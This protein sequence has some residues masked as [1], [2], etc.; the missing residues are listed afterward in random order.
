MNWHPMETAPKDETQ[1][2]VYMV[3]RGRGQ[4]AIIRADDLESG[5]PYLFGVQTLGWMPLPPPP[6]QQ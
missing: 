4:H 2:M 6:P 5:A 1:I 3:E